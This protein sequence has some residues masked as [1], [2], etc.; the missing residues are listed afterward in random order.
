MKELKSNND[1]KNKDCQL[2]SPHNPFLSP[3]AVE[4]NSKEK[5]RDK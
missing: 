1:S 3:E 5:K 4:K 2:G